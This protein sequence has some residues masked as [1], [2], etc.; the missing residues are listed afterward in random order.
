MLQVTS[1][2]P[3]RDNAR[4]IKFYLAG[5]R[6]NQGG[7]AEARNHSHGPEADR[8]PEVDR[9]IRPVADTREEGHTPVGE[10]RTQ[11][12]AAH[13]RAEVVRRAVGRRAHPA[14]AI[15]LAAP[16]P[17]AP[18]LTAAHVH[19][20]R[21]VLAYVMCSKPQAGS[22]ASVVQCDSQSQSEQHETLQTGSV[23]ASLL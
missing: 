5:V 2:H 7:R 8:D 22:H 14:A 9:N 18:L 17:L 1:V 11:A 6:S 19:Y 3:T 20:K 4:S 15:L 21:H 10:A 23:D 12:A 16:L 13:S